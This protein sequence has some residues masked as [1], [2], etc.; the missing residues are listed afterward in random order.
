M[1]ELLFSYGTL[2]RPDV[3]LRLFGRTVTTSSDQLPGFRL[4]S[5]EI[6]NP[7]F[8][9]EG[10]DPVQKIIEPTGKATDLVTGNTLEL[11][12]EELRQCDAYE[13]PEYRRIP[14]Q[15]ESGRQA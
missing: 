3:Q 14:V 8:L 10:E 7:E 1:K 12:E 13:P 4:R 11:T 2:Q 9:D 15:L 5:I 6:S